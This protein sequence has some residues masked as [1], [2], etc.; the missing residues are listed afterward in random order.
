MMDNR[1][2]D[3]WNHKWLMDMT[4]VGDTNPSYTLSST[5]LGLAPPKQRALKYYFRI[6]L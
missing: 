3:S 4:L 1:F 5:G 6:C 2:E